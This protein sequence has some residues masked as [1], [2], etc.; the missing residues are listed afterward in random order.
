MAPL[1]FGTT[2]KHLNS[3][4]CIVDGKGFERLIV[5]K[6][7]GTD[8]KQLANSMK[9]L[10]GWP[11]WG[12]N[13]INDH[14]LGKEMIWALL[15]AF[16]NMILRMFGIANT[17]IMFRLIAALCRKNVVANLWSIWSPFAYGKP[18][19]TPSLSSSHGQT[20]QLL[21]RM[22]SVLKR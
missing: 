12:A 13:P 16:A 21:Q 22:R 6:P 2:A 11:W 10:L 15:P 3:A 5:E 17:S 7:F 4:G 14:Y 20:S 9:H 18:H 19:L 1:F 8:Y